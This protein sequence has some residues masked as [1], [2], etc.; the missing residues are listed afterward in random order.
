MTTHR[1]NRARSP[2]AWALLGSTSPC[3][4]VNGGVD[5]LECL[6]S[7]RGEPLAGVVWCGVC[8]CNIL[9]LSVSKHQTGYRARDLGEHCIHSLYKINVLFHSCK[10]S[11]RLGIGSLDFPNR[12]GLPLTV[13]P[14]W[15]GIAAGG[16]W[17]GLRNP[18]A[19]AS[20]A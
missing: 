7:F 14:P 18:E 19:Q 10:I 9:I 12:C 11:S 6:A 8:I 20:T 17:R 4:D 13:P 2:L 16:T 3:G 5:S 15:S 1:W